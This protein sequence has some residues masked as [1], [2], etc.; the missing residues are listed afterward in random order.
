MDKTNKVLLAVTAVVVIATA[1]YL[2]SIPKETT[3][4][5]TQT[6][7]NNEANMEGEVNNDVMMEEELRM[8]EELMMEGE[9][10]P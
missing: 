3:N 4:T 7:E 2:L 1:I 5:Y 10:R 6:P 8:E 9:V